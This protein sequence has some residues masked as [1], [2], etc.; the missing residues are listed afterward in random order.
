MVL[1][2]TLVMVSYQSIKVAL[3]NPVKSLRAE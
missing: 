2:L 3:V 1:L